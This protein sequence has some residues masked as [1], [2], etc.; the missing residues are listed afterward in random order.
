MTDRMK[1]NK[2]GTAAWTRQLN[3]LFRFLQLGGNFSHLSGAAMTTA[4]AGHW[5][6]C[7]QL[8]CYNTD[9]QGQHG[10]SQCL[11]SFNSYSSLNSKPA[12]VD[13]YKLQRQITED[14]LLSFFGEKKKKS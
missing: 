4:D 8:H 3:V 6:H 2:Q 11:D 14:F 13:T 10:S 9:F 7:N 12:H 5:L 1:K